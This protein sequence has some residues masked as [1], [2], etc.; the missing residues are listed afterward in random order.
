MKVYAKNDDI[1]KYIRH[2][3][4]NMKFNDEGVAEWPDDQFTR[5][6]LRDGDITL[7]APQRERQQSDR[8]QE[9]QAAE[10][11]HNRGRRQLPKPDQATQAE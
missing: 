11:Q 6:R 2:W 9:Q 1:R 7:E 4:T 8:A 5:R 10:G 3:P